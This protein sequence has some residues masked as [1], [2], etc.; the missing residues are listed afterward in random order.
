ML[1]VAVVVLRWCRCVRC[2]VCVL[3]FGGGA[4][5][6]DGVASLSVLTCAVVVAVLLIMVVVLSVGGVVAEFDV[7]CLR[8][9]VVVVVLLFVLLQLPMVLLLL[10]YCV[11]L[12]SRSSICWFS[13]TCSSSCL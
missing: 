2:V 8:V 6:A 3:L 11:W 1:L 13:G 10:W 5:V 12:C 9:A 4:D 7:W